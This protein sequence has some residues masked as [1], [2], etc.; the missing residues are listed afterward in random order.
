M[1]KQN[2]SKMERPFTRA[3]PNDNIS[4]EQVWHYT[5]RSKRYL[6][7]ASR[8]QKTWEHVRSVKHWRWCWNILIT[9]RYETRLSSEDDTRSQLVDTE[10]KIRLT[11]V[12]L[13][14]EE[15]GQADGT[16]SNAGISSV[17]VWTYARKA[18][19]KERETSSSFVVSHNES[20]NYSTYRRTHAEQLI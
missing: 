7:K 17:Y 11:K 3:I 5:V 13:T 9:R 18:F 6:G 14:T 2:I 10:S 16:D 1:N 20:H 12:S 15:F 8:Q 4:K 19:N